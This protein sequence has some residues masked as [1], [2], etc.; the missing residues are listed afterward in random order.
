MVND[1]RIE[2][3]ALGPVEVPRDALYGAQT[4]RAVENFRVSGV[5]VLDLP[6]LLD[7]LVR[8]KTSAARANGEVGAIAPDV[9]DAIVR[10]GREV[11]D[12]QWRDQFPVD[13]VQGGGG[14]ATN[15]NVNEV[16]ANRAAELL[17]GVR[18][19]Y[20]RVHPN[21]HVNR[22]QS[23]NDVYPTA[24]QL[25]VIVAG[26]R[27]VVDFDH[28]ASAFERKASEYAGLERIGRTCLRD[29][30]PM[31]VDATHRRQAHAIARTTK[32]LHRALADLHEVPVGAT[33]IGTGFGAP[34]RY[35]ELVIP[36][37]SD[38]AGIQL[39]ASENPFDA[40]SHADPLLAVASALNRVMLVTAQIAQDLRLLSSGPHGGLGEVVLPAVQVGSSAMPGKVNPVMPELV[41]QVGFEVRGACRTIEAAVAAGEFELN[42]M[43]PVIAKHLLTSL[44]D[45]GRMARLFADRCVAG[46]A[47]DATRV[48]SNLV[49]SYANAMLLAAEA[50]YAVASNARP[51]GARSAS[52][53]ASIGEL[54]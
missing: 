4:T 41:L 12:G 16:L 36:A 5:A 50:G 25:A 2:H 10:A 34:S 51:A 52:P 46:L 1:I 14:T 38:E 32:D 33:V 44:R 21:D 17:G 18:G 6:D 20:D 54:D 24:V 37:L 53:P 35:R 22:S 42:V 48:H 47:W 11:L 8:V 40:M 26:G 30:L 43:E 15:M 9:S 7:G 45:A 13:I 28:L 29:A 19:A 31:R 3:D 27:A 39:T 23:T 49:G